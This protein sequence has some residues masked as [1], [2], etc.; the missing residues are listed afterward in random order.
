M[1]REAYN[2]GVE[3]AVKEASF[4]GKA[5]AAL[6]GIGSFMKPTAAM[7]DKA[8]LKKMVNSDAFSFASPDD[9][10]LILELKPGNPSYK[11]IEGALDTMKHKK[12]L[13]KWQKP[14][15]EFEGLK[16]T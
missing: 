7:G 16:R 3:L 6:I 12:E 5:M 11:K 14:F 15:D 13:E 10:K 8:L 9:L 1:L 4:K 2:A